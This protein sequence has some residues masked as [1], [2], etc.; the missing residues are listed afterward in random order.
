[1]G[2]LRAAMNAG[3]HSLS[4]IKTA[5]RATMGGCQGNTCIP[6]INDIMTML[7]PNESHGTP[8]MASY[9]PPARPVRLEA[10]SRENVPR[11]D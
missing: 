9:R 11:P 3:Y 1:M 5:T 8:D 6:L 10:F 7:V 4:D 2:D